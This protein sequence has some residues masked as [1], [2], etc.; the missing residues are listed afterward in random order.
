VRLWDADTGKALHTL[1]GHADQT[2]CVVFSPDGKQL[3][4]GGA[5]NDR[6][7]RLWDS[8]T[9]KELLKL[10]RDQAG[11]SVGNVH[12]VAFH[13]DGRHLAAACQDGTVRIWDVAGGQLLHTLIGDNLRAQAVNFS[14]DGTRLASSR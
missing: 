1:S 9:G 12:A 6:T 4:S 14:P 7:V 10:S 2:L 8:D 3:A 5:V 13:P 11:E